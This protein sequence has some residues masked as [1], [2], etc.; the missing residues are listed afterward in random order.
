M[1]DLALKRSQAEISL[2]EAYENGHS[3]LP[4]NS[5]SWLVD[6]RKKSAAQFANHGLPH[7]RV[8][9]W[10][11]TDLRALLSDL[12]PV[13]MQPHKNK[14]LSVSSNLRE[15]FQDIERHTA[16]FVNGFFNTE[17]S[18]LGGLLSEVDFLTLEEAIFRNPDWVSKYL[19]TL[20]SD[21]QNPLVALNTSLMSGGFAL[22]VEAGTHVEKP[23]EFVF[24]SEGAN[25]SSVM[26]RGLIIVEEGAKVSILESHISSNVPSHMNLVTEISVARN[27]KLSLAKIQAQEANTSHIHTRFITMDEEARLKDFT[28]NL[29][30]QMS[31]NQT[32]LS[33][34]G[35]GAEADLAGSYILSG[36]AHSDTTLFVDHKVPSCLSKELFKGVLAD[37]ST[38]VFQ[39]KIIVHRDA[40]HTD[41]QMMTQG[42]LLS[43]DA[44]FY[45]KPEL[46][47]Y[48][49]DVQCAHGATSGQI[50]E[51]LMFY[52]LSRGIPPEAAR[53]MIIQAF[54]SETLE[55]VEDED[56]ASLMAEHVEHRLSLTDG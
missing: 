2:V 34:E 25:A 16:V 51:E 9:E 33:F 32:H 38:G 12:P 18:N 52:L 15:G 40:Q 31:R 55:M 22:R 48:A 49:D 26:A 6:L 50:D 5:A 39:G 56:I 37:T 7:K 20:V 14:E 42:L 3:D 17:L 36:K 41:G 44:H 28:L 4:G 35:E 19:N 53:A 1:N 24:L 43:E 46:E 27:A 11:Y 10:K 47:I 45:T 23:I 13:A 29:G 30:A 54:L 8:E 21:E